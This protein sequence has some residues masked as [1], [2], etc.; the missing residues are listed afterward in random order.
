VDSNQQPAPR[1]HPA[2]YNRNAEL[3]SFL[4]AM[5]AIGIRVTLK[6]PPEPEPEAPIE[7]P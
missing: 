2:P 1:R 4:R 6:Q 5:A 7:S 3:H